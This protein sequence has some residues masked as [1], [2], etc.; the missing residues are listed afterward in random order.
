[1][2]GD[3]PGVVRQRQLL[4]CHLVTGPVQLKISDQ[5]AVCPLCRFKAPD[6]DVFVLT[7]GQKGVVAD[8]CT[9]IK[10]RVDLPDQLSK[11]RCIFECIRSI[12]EETLRQIAGL[13][14]VQQ[15]P[16]FTPLHM[17]SDEHTSELHSRR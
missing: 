16:I 13:I 10:K 17:S 8:I 4:Y 11:Q 5:I 12:P 9:D 14:G 1:M 7:A 3:T 2:E 6:P 15:K